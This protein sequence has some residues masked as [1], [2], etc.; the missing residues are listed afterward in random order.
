MECFAEVERRG[1]T[2]RLPYKVAQL[3]LYTY[4][5]LNQDHWLQRPE[6]REAAETSFA[7]AMA[8][9]MPYFDVMPPEQLRQVY[10]QERAK[11]FEGGIEPETLDA[12]MARI[13]LVGRENRAA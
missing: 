5:T 9:F 11:R 4:F 8:R 2:D 12:W 3:V 6:A 1:L 7:K 13:G 10:N